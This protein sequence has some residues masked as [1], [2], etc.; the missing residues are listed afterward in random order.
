MSRARRH[1]AGNTAAIEQA[2]MDAWDAGW[3]TQ[4]IVEVMPDKLGVNA[5]SVRRVLSYMREGRGDRLMA[6]DVIKSQSD[7]LVIALRRHHPE[8]CGR[9]S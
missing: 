5:G 7:A 6:K 1:H 3:T 2:V 9:L 4:R 8:I